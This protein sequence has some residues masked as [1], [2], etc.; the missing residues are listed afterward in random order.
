MSSILIKLVKSILKKSNSISEKYWSYIEDA[1]QFIE[2]IN[3][4]EKSQRKYAFAMYVSSHYTS[5]PYEKVEN[6]P[7]NVTMKDN[8]AIK[9]IQTMMIVILVLNNFIFNNNFF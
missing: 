4:I 8:I 2:K 5:I 3:N 6:T 9:T 7:K 1:S